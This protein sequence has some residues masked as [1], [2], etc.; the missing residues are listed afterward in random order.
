MEKVYETL[1]PLKYNGNKSFTH[2]FTLD[3]TLKDSHLRQL[4][5]LHNRLSLS[6]QPQDAITFWI[7]WCVLLLQHSILHDLFTRKTLA[8][9]IILVPTLYVN[10][11][12]RRVELHKLVQY[13]KAQLKPEIQEIKEKYKILITDQK[14]RWSELPWCIK[15]ASDKHIYKW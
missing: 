10:V 4:V 8:V 15:I 12:L 1:L 2:P 3:P 11:G 7:N 9:W 5:V 14:Q 13:C 6:S